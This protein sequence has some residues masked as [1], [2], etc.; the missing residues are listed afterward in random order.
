M[1]RA[2]ILSG[3]GARGAFQIGVW[4]YLKEQN[5]TPDLVCGT[6]VGAIN[7]VAIGAGMPIDRLFEIWTTYHRPMIY[8]FRMLRFLVNLLFGRPPKPV[9]DTGPMRKMV[10]RHL[11]IDALR[12]SPIDVIITAVNVLTARLHLFNQHVIDV[13]HV[14]ASS[15]MP[16]LFPWQKIDGEPYWD[17]GVMA[18]TPL[19]PALESGVDEI[20]VV[21]LSP[22]GNV[23]AAFPGSLTNAMELVFEHFLIGSCQTVLASREWPAPGNLR[24]YPSLAHAG[25]TEERDLPSPTI[26]TVSPSRMLGFRSMLNFSI[27]QARWLI[28]EGYRNARSQLGDIL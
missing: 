7:A 26:K 12:K 14:M 13:D 19:L 8:R 10:T 3:G 28:D 20:I 25:N 6:S 4:K 27:R 21:L 2:L 17:G 18:N 5:W 1:K 15:A 9:M 22:V 11:D 23:P 24:T 16:I